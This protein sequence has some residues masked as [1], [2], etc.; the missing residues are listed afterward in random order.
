RG[1]PAL[2][3]GDQAMMNRMLVALCVAMLVVGSTCAQAPPGTPVAVSGPEASSAPPAARVA[4]PPP[5]PMVPA[6]CA[7][8]PVKLGE[9]GCW[10]VSAGY[11]FGWVY[12]DPLPPLVT[13]S[14]PGTPQHLAGV[15]GAPATSV[16][17]GGRVNTETRSGLRL[18]AGAWLDDE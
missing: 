7:P 4:V 17:L 6:P 18:D 8:S 14:A 9:Q 5:A 10:W 12:T 13:S 15:F 1:A 3:D 2:V 11:L 16:L